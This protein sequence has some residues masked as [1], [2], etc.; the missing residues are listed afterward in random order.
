VLAIDDLVLKNNGRFLYY[1]KFLGDYIGFDPRK[2]EGKQ[3][4]LIN[5]TY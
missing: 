4:K 5:K 1:C 3:E 2:E